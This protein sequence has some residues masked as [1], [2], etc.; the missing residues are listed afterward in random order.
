MLSHSVGSF[1]GQAEKV[2]GEKTCVR[3]AGAE[4]MRRH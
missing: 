3:G 4:I 2:H 1:T